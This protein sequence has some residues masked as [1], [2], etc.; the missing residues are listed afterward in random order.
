MVGAKK[1][2]AVIT[3]VLQILLRNA[4]KRSTDKLLKNHRHNKFVMQQD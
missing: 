3:I 4:F 2:S 1:S